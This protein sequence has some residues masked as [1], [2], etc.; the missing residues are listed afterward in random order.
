MNILNTYKN[1][2]YKVYK[3]AFMNDGAQDIHMQDEY[4][5]I[6]TESF[7]EYLSKAILHQRLSCLRDDMTNGCELGLLPLEAQTEENVSRVIDSYK[8][9]GLEEWNLFPN[10]NGTLIFQLRNKRAGAISIGNEYFSFAGRT[11]GGVRI[12]GKQRVSP[13]AIVSVMKNIETLC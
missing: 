4:T 2:D 5:H 6:P 12:K 13:E 8:G 11:V 7:K 10:T 1:T 3:R 9:I